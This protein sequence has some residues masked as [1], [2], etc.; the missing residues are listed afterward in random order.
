MEEV[1]D[2]EPMS[3]N[4]KK[5][6]IAGSDIYEGTLITTT[7]MFI[8]NHGAFKNKLLVVEHLMACLF[9]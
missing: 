9:T 2:N 4:T 1:V 5:K 6:N 3:N 7:L 8:K